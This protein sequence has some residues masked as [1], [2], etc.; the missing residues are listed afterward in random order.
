MVDRLE[1]EDVIVANWGN[2][3]AIEDG[4]KY[5]ERRKWVGD[6]IRFTTHFHLEPGD[7]PK[8]ARTLAYNPVTG[9]RLVEVGTLSEEGKRV[10]AE[11]EA[12]GRRSSATTILRAEGQV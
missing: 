11:E 8:I 4:I 3:F 5:V 1:G 10:I 12:D 7:G 9:E 6:R 2:R